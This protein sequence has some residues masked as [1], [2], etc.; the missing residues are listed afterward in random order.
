MD[1]A[2]SVFAAL[3]RPADIRFVDMPQTL[4]GKYQY[5]TQAS[6]A[7]LREA[8]RYTKP[9]HSLESAVEDYVQSYLATREDASL[10]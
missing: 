7:K 3:R 2:S 5:F 6:V 4:R 10:D 8:G 1:L 9:F